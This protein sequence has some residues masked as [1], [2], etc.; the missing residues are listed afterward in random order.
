[1]TVSLQLSSYEIR[2]LVLVRRRVSIMRCSSPRSLYS[3]LYRV[4][5][6]EVA[7]YLL[8]V[9]TA[10]S[11]VTYKLVVVLPVHL[12]APHERHSPTFSL[13]K[14][15]HKHYT[16]VVTTCGAYGEWHIKDI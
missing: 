10:L 6:P 9:S 5:Y 13:E 11:I 7:Q 3:A 1:M 12:L 14:R 15:V 8:A 16:Y 2:F 4:M